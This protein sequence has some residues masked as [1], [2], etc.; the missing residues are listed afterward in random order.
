MSFV[1][2][3]VI[4]VLEERMSLILATVRSV[5]IPI[6]V[7]FCGGCVDGLQWERRR[8]NAYTMQLPV[9]QGDGS[10]PLLFSDLDNNFALG[11]M[12]NHPHADAVPNVMDWA[13]EFDVH[14][15]ASRGISRK[16]VSTILLQCAV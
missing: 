15:L 2:A 4:R 10:L 6:R 7:R 9:K 3:I 12:V 5:A 13:V 8:T 16:Y 1:Q 14:L 11:H